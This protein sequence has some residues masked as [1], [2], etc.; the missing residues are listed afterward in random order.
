MQRRFSGAAA[1]AAAGRAGGPRARAPSAPGGGADREDRGD[2]RPSAS[3]TES[4]G[5][6]GGARQAEEAAGGQSMAEAKTKQQEIKRSAAKRRTRA[7]CRSPRTRS[8]RWRS[9]SKTRSSPFRR[10]QDDADASSTRR[11]T[12]SLAA[13]RRAGDADHQPG[14]QGGRLHADLQQVR[15]RAG[16]RRRG[17]RTS[18]T[19]IIQ[20]FDAARRRPRASKRR[21]ATG[22]PSSP[23]LV[24]GE[25]AATRA[26][27]IEDI[28]TLDAAGPRRPLVPHQRQVPRGGAGEPRR[29]APGRAGRAGFGG[30]DLLLVRDPY[31][32][33]ARLLAHAPSAAAAAARGP[34]HGGGRVPGAAVDPT[35]H[36]RAVRGDRRR[37]AGS[38]PARWF[39]PTPWS[40][41][42][43]RSARARCSIRTSCSTPGPRSA[44]G[45]RDPR[46]RGA[47]SRRLR[48]RHRTAASTTSCPRSG[49]VVIED[50]VEIGA[51]SADRPRHARRDADRRGH[52]DRQPG[53]GRAQCADRTRADPVRRRSG[54]AGS[55]QLGDGVVLAGQA[56]VAGHLEI[57]DGAQVAA[58]SAVLQVGAAGAQVAG[59]PAV[60]L[61][62]W[63][64][65]Q[66]LLA[67]A[68]G[69]AEPRCARSSGGSGSGAA[70]E[71]RRRG[72][73]GERAAN[74]LGQPVDHVGAAA[75][76]SVPAGRP[77]ARDRAEEAHRGA[78]ERHRSTSSSSSATSP[79]SR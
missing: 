39:T 30:R 29:R 62:A 35:A 65:Q 27:R 14:R 73:R 34:R 13:D 47:R 79:A 54:I 42:D 31:L 56:G 43:A 23:T 51:N 75:P 52:Q 68:G 4:H 16:L 72:R 64:R 77:R 36:R 70:A 38:A 28:R 53:A 9:S 55:A 22:S 20:R 8:P 5:R 7:G 40:G 17:G 1:A 66:A 71:E 60:E 76:L 44:R 12:R 21:G 45:V 57:G 25:I 78:Q 15:E 49:G 74:G 69:D 3:C 67:P 61:G 26:R 37:A 41:A 33:L 48:L 18:P 59:I 50:D 11:A 24:G 2:R 10:F 46:R 6:Q 32:A 19:A 63:R 58:K